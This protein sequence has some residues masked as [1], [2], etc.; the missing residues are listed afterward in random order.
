M[1]HVLMCHLW[2]N[3]NVVFLDKSLGDFNRMKFYMT[4]QEKGNLLIQVTV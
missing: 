4:E 1:T 2:D 3:E